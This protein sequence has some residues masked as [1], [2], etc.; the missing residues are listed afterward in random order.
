RIEPFVLGWIT[1]FRRLPCAVRARGH[2]V[3]CSGNHQRQARLNRENAL[4]LPSSEHPIHYGIGE[5]QR[6]ALAY[7]QFID[8]AD[9]DTLRNVRRIDG[10]LAG[11]VVYPV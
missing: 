1:E 7:R 4:G 10:P 11:A 6:L 8:S 9:N 2:I 3:I 5:I